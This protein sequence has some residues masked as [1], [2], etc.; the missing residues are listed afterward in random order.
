MLKDGSNTKE[1]YFYHNFPGISNPAHRLGTEER[2]KLI[3]SK[4]DIVGKSV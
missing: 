1:G 4:V 2:V 3:L